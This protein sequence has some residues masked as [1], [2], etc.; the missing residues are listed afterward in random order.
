[1]PFWA[2]F[3]KSVYDSL[4]LP[5]ASFPEQPVGVV[6]LKICHITKKLATDYCPSSNNP[7]NDEEYFN[8]KYQPTEYCQEHTG[9]PASGTRRRRAF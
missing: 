3:I 9:R 5:P 1:L 4:A 8:I 6:K 2:T 7:K